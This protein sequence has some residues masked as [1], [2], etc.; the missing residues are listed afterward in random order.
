MHMYDTTKRSG[1]ERLRTDIPHMHDVASYC[2]G[3]SAYVSMVGIRHT[4]NRLHTAPC[5]YT[6][7]VHK[8][9]TYWK[10]GHFSIEIYPLEAVNGIKGPHNASRPQS[11]YGHLALD[12]VF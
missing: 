10:Q 7:G 12:D 3:L 4:F 1:H 8:G 6:R 2:L 5:I 11:A 9:C